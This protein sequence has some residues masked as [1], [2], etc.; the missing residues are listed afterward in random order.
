MPKEYNKKAKKK[1]ANI[2]S[3]E[4]ILPVQALTCS[5]ILWQRMMDL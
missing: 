1:K 3:D 4:V 2:A 5:R